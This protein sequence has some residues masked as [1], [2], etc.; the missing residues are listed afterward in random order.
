MPLDEHMSL[1]RRVLQ[2]GGVLIAIQGPDGCFWNSFPGAYERFSGRGAPDVVVRLRDGDRCL[3][4]LV[5][6]EPATLSD[7]YWGSP[8]VSLGSKH[9]RYAVRLPSRKKNEYGDIAVFDSVFEK[10]DILRGSGNRSSSGFPLRFPFS[11][12]LV[13][14]YLASRQGMLLHACAVDDNGLGYTFG[15]VSG[16]GKSTMARLWSDTPGARVLSDDCSIVRRIGGEYWAYGTP[17]TSGLGWAEPDRVSL[18]AMHFIRH[19]PKNSLTLLSATEAVKAVIAQPFLAFYERQSLEQ[20]MDFAVEMT[21]DVP[22]Y[23]LGFVPDSS[24][25]SCVRGSTI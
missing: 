18:K 3:G 6:G 8:L 19:K 5:G 12:I 10:V 20:M 17:W 21:K 7:G 24:A 1:E 9:P 15:G 25:I 14:N 23:D 4:E 13:V 11:A 2:I 22:C 16:T